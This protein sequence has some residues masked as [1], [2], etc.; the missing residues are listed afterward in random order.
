MEWKEII[1]QLMHD[2][3]YEAN[4]ELASLVVMN[5]AK[6]VHYY[7]F[8]IGTPIMRHIETTIVH[9]DITSEYYIFLSAP[10]DSAKGVSCWHKVALY[11]GEKCRLDSYTSSITCRHF[12]KVAQKEK[13]RKESEGD[14]LEYVDYQ[15]LLKCESAPD[16][17]EDSKTKCMQRSYD[18]LSDRDKAILRCL[19]IEKMSAL[20]AYPL[21]SDF[22]TPRP[23]GDMTSDEV[24][25]SWTN[26]QRQDAL[27]LL[28]GRAL[29]HLQKRY[30]EI[31][32]EFK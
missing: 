8:E 18:M 24:K 31:K 15:S 3:D 9:R 20:E 25:A 6:A 30:N 32:K 29:E 10:F 17:V 1:K 27:S 22:I 19:V 23:K 4:R 12:F 26:K 11:K 7:L 13:K 16:D 28:K 21:L 5:D 14:L 2:A